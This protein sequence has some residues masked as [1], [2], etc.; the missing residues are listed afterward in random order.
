MKK[1]L[2]FIIFILICSC[3]PQYYINSH[4]KKYSSCYNIIEKSDDYIGKSTNYDIINKMKPIIPTRKS[5]LYNDGKHFLY[6]YNVDYQGG[7]YNEVLENDIIVF[8]FE[9]DTLCGIKGKEWKCKTKREFDKNSAKWNDSEYKFIDID[10]N[11]EFNIKTVSN[12]EFFHKIRHGIKKGEL[13]RIIGKP[14]YSYKDNN[15]EQWKFVIL[16]STYVRLGLLHTLINGYDG[17]Y[18]R[19]SV[20]KEYFITLKDN[21]VIDRYINEYDVEFTI[22]EKD[23]MNKK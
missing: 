2:F 7:V 19:T 11:P 23:C 15:E 17:R 13:F 18:L 3:T 6:S 9:N 10:Q 4:L 16:K 21:I 20:L 5:I 12:N 1:F 22:E 8:T 14:D